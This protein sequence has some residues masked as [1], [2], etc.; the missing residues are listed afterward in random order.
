MKCDRKTKA[1]RHSAFAASLTTCL[2]LGFA[3]A[4]RGSVDGNQH[5]AQSV[6]QRERSHQYATRAEMPEG[7]EH[8]RRPD[9]EAR[10]LAPRLRPRLSDVL[11]LRTSPR[12]SV[13][14]IYQDYISIK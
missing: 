12:F 2:C 11:Q 6:W 13:I 1:K 4:A 3:P 9:A 7:S 10:L 14:F 5:D 8:L